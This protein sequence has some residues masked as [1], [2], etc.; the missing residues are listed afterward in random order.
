MAKGAA[1]QPVAEGAA[2]F[3]LGLPR[4][5]DQATAQTI[6]S[7]TTVELSN[8]NHL[9]RPGEP[10]E[11]ARGKL[12]VVAYEDVEVSAPR[13][14]MVQRICAVRSSPPEAG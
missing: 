5:G 9:L 14:A 10:L 2:A 1:R 11:A 3:G 6:V 4:H 12:R 7:D 13:P 8:P